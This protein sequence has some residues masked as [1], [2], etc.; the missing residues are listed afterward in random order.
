MLKARGALLPKDVEGLLVCGLERK[1][2]RFQEFLRR[3]EHAS[4]ASSHVLV[5]TL[6]DYVRA[7]RGDLQIIV[8]LQDGKIRRVQLEDTLEENSVPAVT[9]RR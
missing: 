9:L 6:A 3:L 2:D 7:V 4:C 5:S 1:H 8:R